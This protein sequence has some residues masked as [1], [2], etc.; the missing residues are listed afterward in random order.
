MPVSRTARIAIRLHHAVYRLTGGRLGT[1]FGR[2]EQVLLTT[3]GRTSGEPRTTPLAV[4]VVGDRLVLIASDGGA[5]RDPGWYR[6]LVAHPDVILQRGTVRTP[7]RARTAL[8][9]E[10]AELWAAAVANH[11]GYAGY[12]RRTDRQIPVIVCEPATSGF[13]R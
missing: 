1:H 9:A 10:R 2:L 13:R 3:T 5:P 7:M 8:G 4:T 6:N 11:P 12:E